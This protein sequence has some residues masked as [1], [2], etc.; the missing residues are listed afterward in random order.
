MVSKV[1]GENISGKKIV[2]GVLDVCPHIMRNVVHSY[3]RHHPMY[4]IFTMFCHG[5]SANFKWSE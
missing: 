2:F 1:Y 3:D 4:Y 5:M